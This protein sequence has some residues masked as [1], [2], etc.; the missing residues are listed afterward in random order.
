[1][2]DD[3]D[4][5]GALTIIEGQEAL[6]AGDT[7]AKLKAREQRRARRAQAKEDGDQ[8]KNIATT[9]EGLRAAQKSMAALAERLDGLVQRVEDKD[10]EI[11]K[12]EQKCEKHRRAIEG[13][14]DDEN[15]RRPGVLE[16]LEE[17]E[18]GIVE[19]NVILEGP[20]EGRDP[21]KP[22]GILGEIIKARYYI[23]FAGMSGA[24]VGGG[25][26]LLQAMSGG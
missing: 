15:V 22:G 12:L 10:A 18:S 26:D 20:K 7:N 11:A 25:P 8:N 3:D 6:E 14:T 16:R 23:A 4:D 1:M 17:A 21:K 24:A 19:N 13:Y 5:V 2:T 9:T